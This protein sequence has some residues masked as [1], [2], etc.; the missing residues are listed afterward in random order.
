ME[1]HPLAQQIPAVV[2]VRSLQPRKLFLRVPG[3]TLWWDKQAQRTLVM[4]VG[5][6]LHSFVL[7]WEVTPQLS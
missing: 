2:E 5:V 3:F 7:A 4:V 1:R 6:E